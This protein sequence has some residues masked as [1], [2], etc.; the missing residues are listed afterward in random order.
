MLVE[1]L[2][3]DFGNI[4]LIILVIEVVQALGEGLYLVLDGSHGT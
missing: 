4:L 2:V 1:F 3:R